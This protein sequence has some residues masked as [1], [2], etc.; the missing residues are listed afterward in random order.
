MIVVPVMDLRAGQCVHAKAGR[1]AEYRPLVSLLTHRAA[2][3]LALAAA[4]HNRI[5]AESIYVADLD[6]ILD[7]RPNWNLL[8]QLSK[9]G[10]AIWADV[11]VRTAARAVTAFEAGVETL[12]LGLETLAGPESLREIVRGSSLPRDRFLLSLDLFEGRP[13]MAANHEWNAG[14]SLDDVVRIAAELG[15]MRFLILDLAKV[16]IG[17]GVGGREWVSRIAEIVPEGEIW[18]GGGVRD[19]HDLEEL[20]RMP[21]AGVLVGSTLHDGSIGREHIAALARTGRRS[22]R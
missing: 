16:G 2:E 1:R 19:R 5:G 4:Y 15:L 12:V 3:P 22:P 10:A 13:L 21:I 18:L 17:Q 8:K 20:G 9:C 6:A 7:N 11:G 14:T